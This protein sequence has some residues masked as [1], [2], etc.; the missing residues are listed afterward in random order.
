MKIPAKSLPVNDLKEEGHQELLLCR[1]IFHMRNNHSRDRLEVIINH[2]LLRVEGDSYRST[3]TSHSQQ[4]EE[5]RIGS[6]EGS[7][8]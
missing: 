6:E 1:D 8:T 2:D 3:A 7:M 5:I 4:L